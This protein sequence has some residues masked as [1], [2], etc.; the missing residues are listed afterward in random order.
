MTDTPTPPEEPYDVGDRVRV[1]LADEDA[2]SPFEETVGRVVHVF[3]DDSGPDPDPETDPDP[4]RELARAAYRLE[5]AESGET[6]PVV[7]RHRDLV[8]TDE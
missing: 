5:D 3:A 8:S 2:E 6:L 1:R 7:F 4:D